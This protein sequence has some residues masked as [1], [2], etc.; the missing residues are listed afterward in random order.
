MAPVDASSDGT[1]LTVFDEVLGSRKVVYTSV[2]D[3]LPD[4]TAV[5]D[6]DGVITA[7]NHAWRMFTIDNGGEPDSTGVGVNYLD[8]CQRSAVG[9][10]E[11]AAQVAVGLRAVLAGDTVH[12]EQEYPC[13]SPQAHRWFL[14]RITPLV[15]ETTGA[16]VSHV[17]ITRRKMAEQVL[18][19]QAAHDPLTSLANRTR[20]KAVLTKALLERPGRPP[21]RD[22][23][24]LYLDLDGFK[25]VNDNY[26]HDAGDEVLLAAAYRL[27]NLVR[28]Q[29]TVARLGGDEFAIAAPR[30]S[31]NG[32][33]ELAARITRTLAV[34]QVIHGHSICVP[35]SVGFYLAAS[36][37]AA[38][39]VIRHADAAMYVVKRSHR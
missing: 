3:A 19:H 28:A 36:G 8:V 16:V 23:G 30:I 32:L 13:P 12:H 34:P 39:D 24:V 33:I 11:D 22:V 14:L 38:D 9:G 15:R 20:F 35:T 25:L 1:E 29:D 37:E 10:C 7:V 5:L 26:G 6:A 31:T 27:R 21:R 2:L 4:A 18:E 17:N